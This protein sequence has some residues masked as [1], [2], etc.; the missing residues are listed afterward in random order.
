MFVDAFAD[1]ANGSE[2]EMAATVAMLGFSIM[3]AAF[4]V[5]FLIAM[6]QEI[7]RMRKSAAVVVDTGREWE[8]FI[9]HPAPGVA[10]ATRRSSP[11]AENE[12]ARRT[13][14]GLSAVA[15]VIAVATVILCIS[16][17]AQA[18]ETVYN[19]PSGDIL[20]R[21]KVYGELD[22][23]YAPRSASRSFTPRVVVG[24]GHR[25]EIGMNVNGLSA[26]G[27]PQTTLA[28]TIKWKA[29]DGGSNGW[30]FLVG[31]D[32]FIP[33]QNRTYRADN[34]TYAQFTKTW[35]TK[36]RATLGG[37]AITK[38]V[39]DRA[40]RAGGQFAIEQPVTNRL[41][42]AADW[43]TGAHALGYFTPGLILKATSKLTF[44]GTYQ[45]GNRGAS[46]GNHQM[47]I[48]LGYNFN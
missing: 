23:T 19:V 12:C 37:Y 33:V 27:D 24:V 28:P 43:F 17:S 29:Y 39:V 10:R 31:D 20:D 7:A 16:S 8:I 6:H 3:G 32:F 38:N 36:T 30:A 48:E 41:T 44:Y 40:N 2:E 15:V 45:I 26:P 4:L 11:S 22:I 47:L 5:R 13:G 1:T 21:G 18:Q 34:Y 14:A 25:I 42:L 9:E 35:S 46:S